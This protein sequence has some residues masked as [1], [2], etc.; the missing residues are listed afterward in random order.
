MTVYETQQICITGTPSCDHYRPWHDN[1]WA[2]M[3][4]SESYAS[5]HDMLGESS[6]ILF[7]RL[8]FHVMRSARTDMLGAIEGYEH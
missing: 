8:R 1:S 3:P 2:V 4:I 7:H 5:F 6:G